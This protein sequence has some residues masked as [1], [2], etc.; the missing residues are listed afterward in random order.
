MS[1]LVLELQREAMDADSR[2]TDLLRKAIAVARKL[3]V[4]EFVEYANAELAGYTTSDVPP[5]RVVQGELRAHN[6]YN[7][8][9]PVILESSELTRVLRSRSVGQSIAEIEH[10]YENG[11]EDSILT[12]NL[13]REAIDRFFKDTEEYRMGIVPKLIVGRSQM[14]KILD[15]VRNEVLNW[16]LDLEKQGVLGKGLTFSP[17]EVKQAGSIHIGQFSGVWGNV[18]SSNVVIGD[19]ASIHAQLKAAGVEQAARNE[20]ESVLD[21]IGSES[22]ETRKSAVARG[23]D[24]LK[25]YGPA[26]GTL[27]DTIRG[28]L[29]SVN[30]V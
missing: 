16:A 12:M 29:E 13:P 7:G 30:V 26:I 9:I 11:N 8:W 2:V 19:Y 5:Y 6:P 28:W 22:M 1:S 21:D 10:I 14:M 20:I 23:M 25:S 3:G 18:N 17:E 27:S 4:E 15:A 24:W